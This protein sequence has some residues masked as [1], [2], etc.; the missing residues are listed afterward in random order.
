MWRLHLFPF[1]AVNLLCLLIFYIAG[2]YD[3]RRKPFL[4]FV[5]VLRAV[6]AGGIIAIFLFYLFPF[7]L[8]APKTNLFVFVLVSAGLVWTWRNLFSAILSRTTK[9]GVFIFWDGGTEEKKDLFEHIKSRPHLQYE[10]E[11]KIEN[12]DI[13]VVSER[14]KQN[15]EIVRSL[16]QMILAGK[17]VVDFDKFYE[18]LTGKIALSAIDRSWFLE[19]LLEI[20][21]QTFEKFKRVFDII[22]SVFFLFVFLVILIPVAFLIKIESRGPV[23][24]KQKRTGKN[25]KI[26]KIIKFRSMVYA[27]PSHPK[28][29]WEKPNGKD[30]RVT[31]IGNILRKTRLDELPQVLNV[32][33]GHLSFIGPRPERPEFVE[34]LIKGIP[35][36]STRHIVKP[37]LT[38]WAQINFSDA[39]AKDAPEKLRYDLYYIKNRS[40]FLDLSIFLKTI[41]VVLQTSGK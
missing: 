24:Y 7:L 22:L 17:S 35:Y 26:F 11:E 25:G 19:N 41:M 2:F 3:I 27:T 23:F 8:I 13:I 31:I 10:A 15:Q 29:G 18:S 32:L 6:S 16:Y 34:E 1:L 21:K 39:S 12:A 30:N 37:G 38:G 4:G 5:D 36:Y 9:I 33:R 20:N 40:P 14:A 28:E